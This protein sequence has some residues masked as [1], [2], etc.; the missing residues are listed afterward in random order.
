MIK[1]A[2]YFPKAKLIFNDHSY[3]NFAE[4]Y[5]FES[6]KQDSEKPQHVL[7]TS[8]KSES[9]PPLAR[10]QSKQA[11]FRLRKAEPGAQSIA[12]FPT[13]SISILALLQVAQ[14]TAGVD[15]I[16]RPDPGIAAAK[17]MP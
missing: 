17:A 13:S 14:Q 5:L 11:D 8:G 16:I 1:D 12:V 2:S 15:R 6:I 3:L 9:S 10:L 4:K 7:F